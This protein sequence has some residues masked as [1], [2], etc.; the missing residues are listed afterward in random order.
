VS[1][2]AGVGLGAQSGIGFLV[3]SAV[4]VAIYKFAVE[5]KVR[6]VQKL[7]ALSLLPK[8]SKARVALFAVIAAILVF[9]TVVVFQLDRA[10]SAEQDLS[11]ADT[12]LVGHFGTPNSRGF[13]LF[14]GDRVSFGVVMACKYVSHGYAGLAYAMELPFEWTYGI[15]WSRA[16]QIVFHEYLGGPD[17]FPASYLLRNE[18]VNE[19]PALWWWST[20]FPWMASDTTFYGTFLVMILIGF[21]IGSVWSTVI[22]TGNPLGMALLSQ[23]FI[24]VFMFPANNALAQTLDGLSSFVGVLVMYFAF[25]PSRQYSARSV[26]PA[27]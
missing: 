16:L 10:E 22:G 17:I 1:I 15:G 8:K 7:P 18:R 11:E 21:A 14:G 9:G 13:P 27:N 6:V 19:W 24:L 20:I 23:L 26:A 5:R 3:F 4:P 25:R 12:L 2:V